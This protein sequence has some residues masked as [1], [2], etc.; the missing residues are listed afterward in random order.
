ML[1]YA[2]APR[3]EKLGKILP[4]LDSFFFFPFLFFF[5]RGC[6]WPG[7]ATVRSSFFLSRSQNRERLAVL[8]V[9]RRYPVSSFSLWR[10][11]NK[12]CFKILS[13]ARIYIYIRVTAASLLGALIKL[14][15]WKTTGLYAK[16]QST[17]GFNSFSLTSAILLVEFGE[18]I[19]L[20]AIPCVKPDQISSFNSW[21]ERDDP[22]QEEEKKIS[23]K[24]FIYCFSFLK[25]Y[26]EIVESF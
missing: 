23:G 2:A 25:I 13:H 16:V 7:V 8:H 24:L 18:E 20:D 4:L 5:Q 19:M 1:D 17:R 15:N 22:S 6:R 26:L 10:E 3:H 11:N 14:C 9:G 21:N 12:V